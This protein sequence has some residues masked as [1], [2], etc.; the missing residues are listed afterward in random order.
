[1]IEKN[2]SAD[3]N[4]RYF[5][6]HYYMCDRGIIK[7]ITLTLIAIGGVRCISVAHLGWGHTSE[8]NASIVTH[9]VTSVVE[10]ERNQ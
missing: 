1:V 4:E 7:A 6:M 2:L 9:F 8:Q 10:I 3:Y 5:H